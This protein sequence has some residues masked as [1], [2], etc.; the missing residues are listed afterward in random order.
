[1]GRRPCVVSALCECPPIGS[2]SRAVREARDGSVRIAVA[3]SWGEVLLLKVRT[4]T[5]GG[6]AH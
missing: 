2:D 3:S 6:E 1:M 4:A 5:G